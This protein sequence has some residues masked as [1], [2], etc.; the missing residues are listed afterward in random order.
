MKAMKPMHQGRMHRK[1]SIASR[2]LAAE[3]LR[4]RADRMAATKACEPMLHSPTSDD[5]GAP[6]MPH[7]DNDQSIMCN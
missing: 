3:V 1:P 6:A 4:L 2:R 5:P 7:Y